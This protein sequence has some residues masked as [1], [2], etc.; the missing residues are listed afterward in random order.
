VLVI[1]RIIQRFWREEDGVTLV[2]ALAT[3]V[4][5]AITTAGIIVAGTANEDT[6]WA[7]TQGRSAFAVAEESLA[8][9]E[10]MVYSDVVN[11]TTP[12]TTTFN[13]PAQPGNATSGTYRATVVNSTTWHI[14]ATGTVGTVTRTVSAD[15]TPSSTQT[16][17]NTAIWSYIYQ[18]STS[19]CLSITGNLTI[20]VP[21]LSRGDICLSGGSHIVNPSGGSAIAVEAGGTLSDTGGSNIGTS[22]SPLGGVQIAGCTTWASNGSC[23][24]TTS[25]GCTVQPTSVYTVAPG[26]SYCN[27]LQTPLWASSVN[28][29]LSVTPAMPCIGQSSTL[30]PQCPSSTASWSTLNS[31]YN[32]Q[33]AA[34]KTGCPANLLDNDSTLNNSL[35]SSKLS[36]AM[37][38]SNSSYDCKVTSGSTLI[39]EIKW[40]ATGQYCASG[41]LTV[42]GTLIFD[43]SVNLGCGW[44]VIYSGAASLYFTGTFQQSGGTWLCGIAN[45]TTSWNPSVNAIAIVA[46]C[47]SDST[48]TVLVTSGCVHVG[49]GSTAQWATYATTNYQL[50]GG[51]TN[52]GPAM[53]NTVTLGGGSMQMIPFTNLPPGIPIGST[54]T[55]VTGTGP[56]NWSG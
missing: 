18:D 20:T 22:T 37:F 46:A 7:S 19:Q 53:A 1:R 24:A 30:N 10:G 48:G 38:P 36:A 51:S 31:I 43:G 3:M 16:V 29:S 5:L 42:S 50:D 39:G 8:Y 13:L 33:Q 40:S 49:N 41:T 6:S 26:T 12:P 32:T 15:V 25:T 28:S 55:T 2:I 47:W 21:I 14:T 44:K 23:T 35:S 27:G 9:G 4:I 17:Q 54:T 56:T 34:T 45:C 11:G 52:M